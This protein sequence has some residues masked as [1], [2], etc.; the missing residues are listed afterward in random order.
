VDTSV[1][2]KADTAWVLISTALVMLMTPGLALFYGGL[3]RQKNALSTVMDSFF[4]LALVSVVWDFVGY[5]LAFG[6]DIGGVIGSLDWVM[7]TEVGA[8]PEPGYAATIPHAL[9]VAYQMMFAVITPALI[10]G[11]FAKRKRF[12]AFVVFFLLW[13]LTVYSPVAHW[14]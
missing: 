10:S 13:S 1:I 3:V 7:L 2:D 5:S 6:P 14:V 11:A 9:F 8:A 12:S 4:L